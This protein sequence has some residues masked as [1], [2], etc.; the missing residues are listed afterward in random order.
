MDRPSRR[1]SGIQV[2]LRRRA[3]GSASLPVLCGLLSATSPDALAQSAQ[4]ALPPV[5]VEAPQTARPRATTR[6]ARPRS[7]SAGRATRPVA[8]NATDRAS[9]QNK[10]PTAGAARDGLNQA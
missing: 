3:I 7:A 2:M 5:T 4:E 10:T 1:M 8:L 9:A 6:P